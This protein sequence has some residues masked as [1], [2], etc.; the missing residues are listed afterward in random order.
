MEITKKE[1]AECVGL[2]LAEGDHKTTGEITFTNNCFE[3]VKLFHNVMIHLYANEKFKPRICSYSKDWRSEDSLDNILIKHY[4]D[5]R[6][7]R[8]Y[9]LYRIWSV[10]LISKWKKLVNE[11]LTQE[12]WSYDILRGFFAGEGNIKNGKRNRAVRIA[13]KQT[14]KWVDKTLTKMKVKFNFNARERAYVIWGRESWDKLA[15]IR[16]ADL[17]PLKKDRFWQI[18]S[19]F[20]EYHY[21]PG[22]LKNSILG[23]LHKMHTRNEI[24]LILGR[25]PARIN[26]VLREL[27]DEDKIKPFKVRSKVYWIRTDQNLVIISSIKQNY[28]NL[29]DNYNKTYEFAREMQ[30][31]WKSAYRRLNELKK[32]GLVSLKE[33]KW[34]RLPT[35]K[36]L[37]VI[38]V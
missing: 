22:L 35:T 30:V 29:L 24:S 11:L 3:L 15:E 8:P 1:I 12:V 10:S 37:V 34:E 5:L 17:H 31:D 27:E 13:Q 28:L 21:S 9:Y 36:R 18:Y 4:L 19:Q 23:L 38:K 32:L 26:D 7:N 33:D 16:I 20:K 14:L 25:T 6:A 2:W